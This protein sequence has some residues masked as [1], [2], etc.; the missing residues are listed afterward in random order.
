MHSRGSKVNSRK[1]TKR[2]LRSL[3]FEFLPSEEARS[4]VGLR[5]LPQ[6]ASSK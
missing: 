2:F 5:K 6:Y 3:I 1:D 4:R